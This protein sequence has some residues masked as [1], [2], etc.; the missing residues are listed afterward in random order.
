MFGFNF[1]QILGL[2]SIAILLIATVLTLI[3]LLTRRSK[4][5]VYIAGRTT[6]YLL[7]LLSIF[8]LIIY[9]HYKYNIL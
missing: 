1:M 9:A 2:L 3:L 6:L 8:C 4:K 5:F 7:F